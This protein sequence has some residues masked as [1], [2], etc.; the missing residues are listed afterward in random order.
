MSKCR[1]D[2]LLGPCNGG[3]QVAMSS[4]NHERQMI[5]IMN[6][7]EIQRGLNSVRESKPTLTTTCLR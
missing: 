3:W 4:L 5:W 6:W 7:V 2:N 1:P